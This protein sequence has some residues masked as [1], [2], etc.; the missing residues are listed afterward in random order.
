MSYEIRRGHPKDLKDIE[1]L[2]DRSFYGDEVYPG[3]LKQVRHVLHIP[4][5]TFVADS[6][7]DVVGYI[8]GSDTLSGFGLIEYLAVDP[9][10]RR[11]GIGRI[12]MHTVAQ[13]FQKNDISL[14]FLTPTSSSVPFYEK[15]G[16]EER[17]HG[18]MVASVVDLL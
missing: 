14:L 15:L 7:Y 18:R 3:Y 4:E 8:H 13:A 1:S 11:E 9:D 16:F 5:Y 17:G 6:G 2:L 10:W 12:L